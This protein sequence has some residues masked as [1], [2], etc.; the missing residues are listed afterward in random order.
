MLRVP[1]VIVSLLLFL[2]GVAWAQSCRG[3]KVNVPNAKS[4][5]TVGVTA[6]TVATS[7]TSRCSFSVYNKSSNGINCMDVSK[8]G[9][10]TG[11]TGFPIDGGG[12]WALGSES[13]GEI[14]CIRQST[15]VADATVC[16]VEG[17]P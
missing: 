8:D 3:F 7:N 5:M 13:Q 14:R 4:C 12:V 1:V 17:T 6:V 9:T 11:T 16:T 10:P 15:A 2:G